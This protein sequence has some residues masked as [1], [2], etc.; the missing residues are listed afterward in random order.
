MK[1][2]FKTIVGMLT[3]LVPSLKKA[4]SIEGVK[5]T[6]EML[7]GANEVSLFMCEKLKDG[8][9]FSDATD[10]YVKITTD[11]VFKAKMMAAYDNYQKIPAE[12]KDIDGGEG[13]ELAIVQ[14][15]YVPKYI[16]CFKK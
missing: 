5:E 6:K 9:Q 1:G 12:I 16:E 15:E 11:E 7:V 10:F 2:I 4:D 3:L 8:A 14:I 13:V